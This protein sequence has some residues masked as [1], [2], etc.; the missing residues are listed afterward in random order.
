MNA[1]GLPT[2]NGEGA[3]NPTGPDWPADW[4]PETSLLVLGLPEPAAADL[5]RRYEQNAILHGALGGP[6]RLVWIDADSAATLPT[7]PPPK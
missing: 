4:P 6:A 5:A 1:T 7:D 2:F 3:P